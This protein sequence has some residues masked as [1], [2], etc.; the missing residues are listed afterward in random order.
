MNERDGMSKHVMNV[1][2]R[3]W[4]LVR[5]DYDYTKQIGRDGWEW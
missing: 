2:M 3:W 1:L 4:G 5:M